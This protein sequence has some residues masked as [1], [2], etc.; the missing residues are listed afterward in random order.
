MSRVPQANVAYHWN[1]ALGQLTIH[2]TRPIRRGEEMTLCYSI[3]GH[4]YAPRST[5]RRHLQQSFGFECACAKCA[6]TGD[7]LR[8]SEGR[9]AALGDEITFWRR[10]Y[11]ASSLAS[12]D[13]ADASM[14]L[15]RLEERYAMM[16][17]EYPDGHHHGASAILLSFVEFCDH[18]C[19]T[20]RAAAGGRAWAP[21][22]GARNEAAGGETE[23]DREEALRV[24]RWKAA[25]AYAA[26]ARRW[27]HEAC[28]VTRV[29]AGDDSPTFG[30]WCA[31]LDDDALWQP[32]STSESSGGGGG[33]SGGVS[34]GFVQRWVGAGLTPSPLAR[35][36]QDLARP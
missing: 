32:S 9:A 6:L 2:A 27:A 4:T 14:H 22:P 26:G 5:R 25:D 24:R 19:S 36:L 31:A 20:L 1:S 30:V 13:T 8:E 15:H 3:D 34:L 21:S 28:D 12:L 18:A 35:T 23:A 10:L 16:K 29:H 33:G 17:E 11:H 7:A